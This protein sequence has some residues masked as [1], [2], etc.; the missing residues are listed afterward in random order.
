[1]CKRSQFICVTSWK[2]KNFRWWLIRRNHNFSVP[3]E[4]KFRMN[5]FCFLNLLFLL[6]IFL[7]LFVLCHFFGCQYLTYGMKFD[8]LRITWTKKKWFMKK[9]ATVIG[10]FSIRT[11]TK[12]IFAL[13]K[14]TR[15]K[16]KTIGAL[17]CTN[18]AVLIT[19]LK[20]T[21]FFTGF[22]CCILA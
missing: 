10:D 5:F 11:I 19:Q 7:L 3:T 21:A 9:R 14:T 4:I 17:H 12:N 2:T 18:Q 1:M 22:N 20:L 15:E 6:Y 13:Y 16:P 8:N